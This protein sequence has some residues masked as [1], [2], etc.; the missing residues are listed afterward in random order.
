MPKSET[1]YVDAPHFVKTEEINQKLRLEYS[2]AEAHEIVFNR[3]VVPQEILDWHQ[4]HGLE[5]KDDVLWKCK[6]I[7][8][9]KSDPNNTAGCAYNERIYDAGYSFSDPKMATLFKLT[10]GGAA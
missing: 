6:T 10:F 2:K 1:S 5:I 9:K 3:R 4:Q 7:R 8:H